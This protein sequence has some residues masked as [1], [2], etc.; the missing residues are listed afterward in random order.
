[1]NLAHTLLRTARRL[2]GAP[3]V[4]ERDRTQLSYAQLA[5]RAARLAATLRGP[6]AQTPGARVALLMKNNAGNPLALSSG[7]ARVALL[8]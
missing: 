8:R 6:L 4:I 1:M 7:A 2:P 5:D 3:A